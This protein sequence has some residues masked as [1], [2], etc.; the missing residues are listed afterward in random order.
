MIDQLLIYYIQLSMYLNSQKMKSILHV[1]L[2]FAFTTSFSQT[3]KILG[4][5]DR[6]YSKILN[7]ERKIFVYTPEQSNFTELEAEKWSVFFIPGHPIRIKWKFISMVLEPVIS[8]ICIPFRYGFKKIFSRMVIKFIYLIKYWIVNKPNQNRLSINTDRSLNNQL[9]S[10][11]CVTAL[12][13]CH[14][15]VWQIYS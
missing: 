5:V 11:Y 7:E 12:L 4:T 9:K 3:P 2:V 15:F 8:K 13:I 1:L 10:V 14:I 6:I